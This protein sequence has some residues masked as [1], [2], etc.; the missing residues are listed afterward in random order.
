MV[1]PEMIGPLVPMTYVAML[2]VEKWWPARANPPRRGWAWLG[3]GFLLLM[4]VISTVVPLLVSPQ[5]LARLRWLDLSGLGVLGG[6]V[7]GWLVMSAAMFA[8]HRTLHAVPVLWRGIHQLH[9]SPQ[10]LD[11]S[12]SIFFHPTQMVAH[13]LLQMG[14]TLIVLGLDPLAAAITGYVA[15]F[16]DMF[17]H[18]NVRTPRWLGWL[19]QR[20]EAHHEH[21][22]L[23]VHASNYGDL[24]LWDVLAGMFRNSAVFA[25]RIGFEPPADRRLGAMLAFEDVN[26]PLYG[27]ANRGATP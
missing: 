14:V 13:N 8:W 12:G 27:N 11:V 20:P 23:G 17:Q 9:H 15:A 22:R 16:H 21:H 19:I 10:R 4:G 3:I 5:W 25:G 24:P 1:T 26:R 2:L 7:I 18:W 6:A